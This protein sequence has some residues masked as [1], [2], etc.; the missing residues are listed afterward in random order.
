[1]SNIR[2]GVP[3]PFPSL[4]SLCLIKVNNHHKSKY[5]SFSK[6]IIISKYHTVDLQTETNNADDY[7]VAGQW[8]LVKF[9]TKS[10]V[11]HYVGIVS[12]VNV[13]FNGK[14]S[15]SEKV[16]AEAGRIILHLH[17]LM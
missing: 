10:S 17:T 12:S 11:K 4:I 2:I 16:L 8:I 6:S 7:V 1:M 3:S 5:Q 9:T 14:V 15:L 13:C